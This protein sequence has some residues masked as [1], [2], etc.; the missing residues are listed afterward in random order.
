MNA[1]PLWQNFVKFFRVLKLNRIVE[2]SSVPIGVGGLLISAF[3]ILMTLS[4]IVEKH[5]LKIKKKKKKK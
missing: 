4:C 1:F 2:H 3:R 5:V